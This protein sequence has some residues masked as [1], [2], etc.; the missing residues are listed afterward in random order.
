M[1]RMRHSKKILLALLTVVLILPPLTGA[2]ADGL[3]IDIS[4]HHCATEHGAG[5]GSHNEAEADPYQCDQC[6]IVL[7][8]LPTYLL[9]HFSVN[10]LNPD[11][12][13]VMKL[14]PVRVPP[15]FK[16]PNILTANLS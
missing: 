3:G 13:S 4:D 16:P 7:S 2:V 5:A 10:S 14:V 11:I 12:Q 15:F 1:A 9:V 8:A 6:H